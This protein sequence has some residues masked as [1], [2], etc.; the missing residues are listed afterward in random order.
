MRCSVL[1]G[2]HSRVCEGMGASLLVGGLSE[3]VKV[4][5]PGGEG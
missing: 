5:V 2:W 4:E 1:G 3:C